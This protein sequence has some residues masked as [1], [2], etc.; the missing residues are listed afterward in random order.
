LLLPSIIMVLFLCDRWGKFG[1]QQP[2]EQAAWE[3][4]ATD[5]RCAHRY[6]PGG[7]HLAEDW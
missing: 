7:S 6:G 1:S 5:G 2:A 3:S 4:Q